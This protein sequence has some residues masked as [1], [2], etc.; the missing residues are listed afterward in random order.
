MPIKPDDRPLTTEESAFAEENHNFVYHWLNRNKLG[1]DEWYDIVVFGYL[2]AVREWFHRPDL[3]SKWKF[4]TIANMC[5]R[6]SVVQEHKRR[7]AKKRTAVVASL[8]ELIYAEREVTREDILPSTDNIRDQSEATFLMADLERLLT[9]QQLH[10][11]RMLLSGCKKSEIAR[12]FGISR[13]GACK[14]IAAIQ[15][16][17]SEYIGKED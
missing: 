12:G 5:M 9:D 11:V 16:R 17:L 8:Q 7:L 15:G 10:I 6:R 2:D 13:Q 4:T 1:I 14:R 3:R